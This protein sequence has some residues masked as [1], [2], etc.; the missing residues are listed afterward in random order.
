MLFRY[1]ASSE[2]LRA[3]SG[4]L[5]LLLH[6]RTATEFLGVLSSLEQPYYGALLPALIAD[7]AVVDGGALLL[8]PGL[9]V[10]VELVPDLSDFAGPSSKLTANCTLL[11][12]LDAFSS[13]ISSFLL[14][15]FE[16]LPDA[17]H[18]MG[19][20]AGKMTLVQEPVIF[21]HDGMFMNAALLI[22]I[23]RRSGLGVGHGWER[24][25]GPFLVTSAEGNSIRGLDY[26]P[27]ADLYC[28][29]V[30]QSTGQHFAADNFFDLAKAYP[31]GIVGQGS[32]VVVR[33][34]VAS[35]GGSIALVGPVSNYAVVNILRGDNQSLLKAAV[36]VAERA[37]AGKEGPTHE[38]LV[39]DCISRAM[40]LEADFQE[41]LN[42]IARVFDG[43]PLFGALTFG[44]IASNGSVSIEFHNKTCV[45]AAL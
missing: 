37:R 28:D 35:N 4:P 18:V 43:T 38:V 5:L 25:Q 2:L 20:G 45:V 12:F 10:H 1:I 17:C 24:F 26:G 36:Q 13:G 39:F 30:Q 33:D 22:G 41:E 11:C 42:G 40:F 32:E 7:G 6:E 44:E 15:L 8:D 9:D 16:A 14:N 23:E 29:V 21:S 31:F 34:P 3:E 19:G 27:A